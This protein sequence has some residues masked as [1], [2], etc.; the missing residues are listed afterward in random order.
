[1]CEDSYLQEY[2]KSHI[3]KN[4]WK[5]IFTRIYKGIFI[6]YVYSTRFIF[7]KVLCEYEKYLLYMNILPDSYLQ[8][9][10]MDI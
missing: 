10:L 1:M 7:A 8:E 6:M 3:Y 2:M 4:M 9:S 5:V